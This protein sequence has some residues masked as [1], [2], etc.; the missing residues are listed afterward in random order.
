MLI[1]TS[2]TLHEVGGLF[3]AK[4]KL[5]VRFPLSNGK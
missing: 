5:Q 1:V 4:E 2:S 3:R